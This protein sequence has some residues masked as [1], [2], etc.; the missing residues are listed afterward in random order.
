MNY[1]KKF[2]QNSY[3]LLAGFLISICILWYGN[4]SYSTEGQDC[5]ELT[6]E[7]VKSGDFSNKIFCYQ[8]MVSSVGNSKKFKSTFIYFNDNLM[9]VDIII[10]ISHNLGKLKIPVN[11]G[12]TV[13]VKGTIHQSE[14]TKK[15]YI[16][17]L[18]LADVQVLNDMPTCANAVP[19]DQLSSYMNN[20]VSVI[21]SG[22]DA[23]K[24]KSKKG[25]KHL[26]LKFKSGYNFYKGI[27]WSGNYNRSD[28]K[29][30]KSGKPLCVTTK[31][32][33]YNGAI[34]LDVKRIEYMDN[35]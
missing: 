3:C 10:S 27:M 29:K 12:D 24:F 26:S 23:I 28:I 16:N 1:L 9:P 14:K 22:I 7:V 33:T 19:S 15:I 4:F 13:K 35:N 11:D 20:T 21:L 5:L 34:S 32:G 31:V 6:T 2:L 18:S 8:G 30:V 17:P 25:K